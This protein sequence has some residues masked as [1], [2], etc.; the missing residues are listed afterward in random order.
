MQMRGQP[1]ETA[2]DLFFY[3]EPEEVEAEAA[4]GEFAA[5]APAGDN[6][7]GLLEG[8]ELFEMAR[9]RAAANCLQGGL[10]CRPTYSCMLCACCRR[11]QYN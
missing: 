8:R 2:V 6:W 11:R 10:A 9:M 4:E 1:L 3:R 5:T 7:A